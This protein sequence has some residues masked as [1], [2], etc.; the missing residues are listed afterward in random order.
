MPKI[1]I[2]SGFVLN[3]AGYIIENMAKPDYVDVV[4]GNPLKEDVKV[5][6]PIYSQQTLDDYAKKGLILEY[7]MEGDSL[8][9]KL[10]EVKDIVDNALGKTQN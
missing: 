1:V 4:V 3:L 2:E 5:E 8:K 9:D 10:K 7:L 6:A